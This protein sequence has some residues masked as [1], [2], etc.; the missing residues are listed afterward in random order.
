[1]ERDLT[2]VRKR[3]T[4]LVGAVTDATGSARGALNAELE[5]AQNHVT[6]LEARLGAVRERQDVLAAQTID[7]A[8]VARAVEAFA[9]IWDVLLQAERERVLKLLIDAVRY[10]GSTQQ[11]DIDF[12]LAGFAELAEEV[13]NA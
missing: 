13:G 2:K 7:E 8:D 1:M 9:P 4:Q 12:R 3:V 5:K 6:T 11:L 10:N